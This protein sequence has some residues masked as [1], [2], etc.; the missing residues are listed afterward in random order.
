MRHM[1]INLS[2]YESGKKF[3]GDYAEAL[4]AVQERLS[5]IQV[6]H[7]VHKKR[8][9]VLFEGWDAAGKGGIIQ[10]LTAEWEKKEKRL[11]SHYEEILAEEKTK[12]QHDLLNLQAETAAHERK[13]NFVS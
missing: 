8:A 3:D 10:R 13:T 11:A 9:L 7:I 2:D 12:A 5:H 6:A 4:I 1:S